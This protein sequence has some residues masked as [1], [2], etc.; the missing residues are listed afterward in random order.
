MTTTT[1]DELDHL[2]RGL[3]SEKFQEGCGYSL[4]VGGGI[5]I[6]LSQHAS[7]Q[8]APARYVVTGMVVSRTLTISMQKKALI[9]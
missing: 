6:R 3:H 5:C 9:C 7:Q 4:A 2:G 1:L 8:P